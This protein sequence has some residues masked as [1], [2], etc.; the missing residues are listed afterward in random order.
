MTIKR[1]IIGLTKWN[2]R[3]LANKMR[4]N[5]TPFKEKIIDE[6][7]GDLYR[8]MGA[9]LNNYRLMYAKHGAIFDVECDNVLDEEGPSG[10]RYHLKYKLARLSYIFKRCD[11]E[12]DDWMDTDHEDDFWEYAATLDLGIDQNGLIN[13]VKELRAAS[14]VHY[15]SV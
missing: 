5:M 12:G 14:L 11:D 1:L 7:C 2:R 13:E 4:F 9:S 10:L 8:V 6:F 3:R 15:E